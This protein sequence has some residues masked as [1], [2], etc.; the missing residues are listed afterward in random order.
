MENYIFT[1]TKMHTYIHAYR[2]QDKPLHRVATPDE[3]R[4]DRDVEED[5]FAARNILR[6]PRIPSLP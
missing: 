1:A 6:W 4:V 5:S 3:V 2:E